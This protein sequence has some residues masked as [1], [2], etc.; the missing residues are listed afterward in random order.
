MAMGEAMTSYWMGRWSWK[1]NSHPEPT[2]PQYTLSLLDEVNLP[3]P[4]KRKVRTRGRMGKLS[5]ERTANTFLCCFCMWTIYGATR[6]IAESKCILQQDLLKEF[7]FEFWLWV[8]WLEHCVSK[9]TF[10]LWIGK[11]S[12]SAGPSQGS[13]K[14]CWGHQHCTAPQGEAVVFHRSPWNQPA[15]LMTH[16]VTHCVVSTNCSDP[17]I[18]WTLTGL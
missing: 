10:S 12:R 16:L 4:L 6:N 5:K 3:N 8:K 1:R 15:S 13:L 7:Y 14:S 11:F 9:Q 17:E 2:K 18:P